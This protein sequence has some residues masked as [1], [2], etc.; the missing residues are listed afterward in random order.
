M[1]LPDTV[2]KST[3]PSMCLYGSQRLAAE[4]LCERVSASAGCT[5]LTGAAGTGKTLTLMMFS[6]EASDLCTLLPLTSPEQVSAGIEAVVR[7]LVTDVIGDSLES[8]EDISEVLADL[9]R[10]LTVVIDNALSWPDATLTEIVEKLSSAPTIRLVLADRSAIVARA[11]S[12]GAELADVLTLTSFDQSAIADFVKDRL[13]IAGH[14]P[15]RCM[16][17]HSIDRIIHYTRGLPHL[18]A[19]LCAKAV[20]TADEAPDFFLTPEHI[21]ECAGQLHLAEREDLLGTASAGH[22]SHQSAVHGPFSYAITACLGGLACLLVLVGADTGNTEL[23]EIPPAILAEAEI[24]PSL[25]PDPPVSAD[26]IGDIIARE[27]TEAP[28]AEPEFGI[29]IADPIIT[30]IIVTAADGIED[31]DATYTMLLPEGA[32]ETSLA[33]LDPVQTASVDQLLDLADDHMK[34]LRLTV[35]SDRNALSVYKTVLEI[36]PENER[37]IAGVRAIRDSFVI[38]GKKRW[39]SNVGRKPANTCGGPGMYHLATRL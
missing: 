35:P 27:I 28:I 33:Q 31:I 5:I 18:T 1:P 23:T 21:G 26:Q 30:E 13:Q 34:A 14:S 2:L 20:P 19:L 22:L 15:D 37:A 39:F 38:W 24:T 6:A 29:T 10:P 32:V 8:L 7:G 11:E 12:L 36:E 16:S 17:E 9:G 3:I 4:T 25:L